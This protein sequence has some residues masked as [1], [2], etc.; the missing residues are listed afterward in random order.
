[1]PPSSN[2]YHILLTYLPYLP[3]G[4][5][6]Y[7]QTLVYYFSASTTRNAATGRLMNSWDKMG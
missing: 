4:L 3:F 2:V 1:M 5:V 7:M 6:S